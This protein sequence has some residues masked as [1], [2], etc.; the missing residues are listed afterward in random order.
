MRVDDVMTRDARACNVDDTLENACRIMWDCDCGVVPVVDGNTKVVAVVTDRD[1]C[2]AALHQRKAL[3]ELP[4]SVAMSRKVWSLRP[5][6]SIDRAERVMQ[7]NQVRRLPVTGFDGRLVGIL[8]LNDIARQ[9]V[10]EHPQNVAD[11]LAAIGEPQKTGAA[12]P[13][14]R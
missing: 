12:S 9:A 13:R 2:M 4:V 5:E 8:S 3:H 14:S 10:R 6:D 11:T 1:A 7:E